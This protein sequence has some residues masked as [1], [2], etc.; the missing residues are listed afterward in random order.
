MA[1]V[2]GSGAESK[3]DLSGVF[4]ALVTPFDEAGEV[5]WACFERLCERQVAAGAGLL[6]VSFT[7]LSEIGTVVQTS[8]R[9]HSACCMPAISIRGA[10]TGRLFHPQPTRRT[11]AAC[12]G[13]TARDSCQAKDELMPIIVTQSFTYRLQLHESVLSPLYQFHFRPVAS[14]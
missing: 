5:D 13:S 12:S 7:I 6:P 10:C 14:A 3:A 9:G 11:E 1:A 4:T 8:I 2:P